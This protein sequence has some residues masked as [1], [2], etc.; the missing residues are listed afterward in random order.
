[1]RSHRYT[2]YT[3]MHVLPFFSLPLSTFHTHQYTANIQVQAE[4]ELRRIIVA[5]SCVASYYFNMKL[6]VSSKSSQSERVV[7]C[8]DGVSLE[9]VSIHEQFIS[10]RCSLHAQHHLQKKITPPQHSDSSCVFFISLV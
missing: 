3:V 10:C 6:I 1:M 2:V 5:I 4:Q 9:Y 7:R 8:G